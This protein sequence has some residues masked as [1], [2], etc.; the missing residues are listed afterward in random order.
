MEYTVKN[1]TENHLIK[2]GKKRLSKQLTISVNR[3]GLLQI[4]GNLEKKIPLT[5]LEEIIQQEDAVAKELF[6]C[7]GC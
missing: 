1:T 2:Y 7:K 4:K 6:S 3:L 5:K